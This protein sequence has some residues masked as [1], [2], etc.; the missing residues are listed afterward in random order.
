MNSNMLLLTEPITRA[1]DNHQ[2]R[3]RDPEKEIQP[4]MCFS[5]DRQKLSQCKSATSTSI[6]P[7]QRAIPDSDSAHPNKV[8]FKAAVDLCMQC[9]CLRL[10]D[11]RE[12]DREQLDTDEIVSS[13]GRQTRTTRTKRNTYE[14]LNLVPDS[15]PTNV[16]TELMNLFSNPFLGSPK[17]PRG[18][19][20]S[21]LQQFRIQQPPLQIPKPQ[22]TVW[23]EENSRR[24]MESENVQVM[25][26]QLLQ[27]CNIYNYRNRKIGPLG[28][29]EGMLTSSGKT[30][31]RNKEVYRQLRITPRK[32]HNVTKS[33][34]YTDTLV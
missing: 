22:S 12:N 23:S 34:F 2:F 17:N 8:Y 20:P 29:G 15:T 13:R 33:A 18:E 28:K 16:R 11:P 1:A 31:L 32:L 7:G 9:C 25:A 6:H 27:R 26:K 5:K 4:R 14:M 30:M 21:L 3:T 24:N 19:P 10:P